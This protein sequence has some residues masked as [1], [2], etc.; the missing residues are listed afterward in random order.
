MADAASSRTIAGYR[1]G[2]ML[3]RGGMGEVWSATH[4]ASGRVVAIK[5]LPEGE[6]AERERFLREMR[7]AGGVRHPR[8]VTCLAAGRDAGS[9]WLAMEAMAGGD[10]GSLCRR[11]GGRLPEREAVAIVRD[12]ARGLQAVHAA[13]LLHRDVKPSNILIAADGSAKI[14]D[15]GLAR[16]IQDEHLTAT[17]ATVGTPEFMSP[18]QA[19]GM[20]ID[21]RADVYGLG[22]TLYALLCGQPPYRGSSAWE[23]A[24]AVIRDPFPDPRDAGIGDDLAAM[25]LCACAREPAGRPADAGAFADGLERWLAAQATAISAGQPDPGTSTMPPAQAQAF[26]LQQRLQWA[27][28]GA[29]AASVALL[30]LWQPWSGQPSAAAE[31][32]PPAAPVPPAPASVAAAAT[33][34]AAKAAPP[35]SPLGAA[36]GGAI[37]VR[38]E[39]GMTRS[40]RQAFDLVPLQEGDPV[41]GGEAWPR[42]PALPEGL[43]GLRILRPEQFP[44]GST[45]QPLHVEAA[46][47]GARVVI[48][49]PANRIDIVLERAAQ[50]WRELPRLG[51]FIP[52]ERTLTAGLSLSVDDA[53]VA[54]EG[55]SVGPALPVTAAT[56]GMRPGSAPGVPSWVRSG[57]PGPGM[58]DTGFASLAKLVGRGTAADQALSRQSRFSL[59]L[60]QQA[61]LRGMVGPPPGQDDQQAAAI[62]IGS[63]W[64]TLQDGTQDTPPRGMP[65]GYARSTQDPRRP[66]PSVG[67]MTM[68]PGGTVAP[69]PDGTVKGARW[70]HMPG[71][72]TD[73]SREGDAELHMAGIAVERAGRLVLALDSQRAFMPGRKNEDLERACSEAALAL[74]ELAWECRMNG[75][76]LMASRWC[77]AGEFLA[78]P[79]LAGEGAKVWAEGAS[80][81][82]PVWTFSPRA[83]FGRRLP[84]SGPLGKRPTAISL[85]YRG[86]LWSLDAGKGWS[87][88]DAE[89]CADDH[90]A[91]VWSFKATDGS[92]TKMGVL[93]ANT[94]FTWHSITLPETGGEL[95]LRINGEVPWSDARLGEVWYECRLETGP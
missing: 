46:G 61:H 88:P 58:P 89:G 71:D 64:L 38:F 21:A 76:V 67:P 80:G 87:S 86:G 54:A 78:V 72:G 3:G 82:E 53:L 70:F 22:A 69:P 10:A 11:R 66:P 1:L 34:P 6:P 27:V 20:D 15:L 33:A 73:L 29:A 51:L 32:G 18:E 7:A 60:A 5:L 93:P 30:L 14:A 83:V 94:F 35:E 84:F 17:G 44:G 75:S 68:R 42:W 28:L 13:G 95:F 55:I 49:L 57:M 59:A 39:Q 65:M 36:A 25:I 16:R 24:A 4:V 9:L 62:V 12:A 8:V 50:G 45:P 56:P 85:R 19:R 41:L 52:M 26:G 92:W 77:E 47:A 37:V 43:S 31:S 90:R 40:G 2:G 79:V 91:A 48:L 81:A 23:V 74:K 63:R